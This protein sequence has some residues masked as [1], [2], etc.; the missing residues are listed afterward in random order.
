MNRKRRDF[1]KI[2]GVSAAYLA[3]TSPLFANS[4]IDVEVEISKK[5][6]T[7]DRYRNEF[8][9]TYSNSQEHGFSNGCIDCSSNCSWE[10][11]TNDNG[12]RRKNQSANYPLID[13]KIP[14][15]NPSGCAIGA[16]L[17]QAM[18]EGKIHYP[19]QRIGARGEGKW[20]SIS[21]D[22]AAK[23]VAENIFELL[24][25]K[26]GGP[27]KLMFHTADEYLGEVRSAAGERFCRQLGAVKVNLSSE[28]GAKFG[29]AT[30]AYGDNRVGCTYDFLFNTDTIVLWGE[31][32]AASHIPDAHYI[33]EAKYN[34]AKVVV[35]SSEFNAS[36]RTADLWVPLKHGSDS[37][38]AMSIMNVIV[39]EK[40]YKSEFMKLYTDL[41]LLVDMDTKKLLRRSDIEPIESCEQ[42]YCW[43]KQKKEI[44]LMPGTADDERRTLRLKEFGIDPELEGSYEITDKNGFPINV[45]TVFELFKQ[46]VSKYRP[47]ETQKFTNVHPD[48]VRVLAN[49]ITNTKVVEIIVGETL[50]RAFNSVNT[51][52][53]IASICGITG[54]MGP[55]GGLHTHNEFLIAGFEQLSDFQG[56]YNYREASSF[57]SDFILGDVK[58]SFYAHYK[59]EDIKRSQNGMSKF[60]HS[61]IL[62]AMLK[63]GKDAKKSG[64]KPW[65]ESQSAIIV[66]NSNIFKGNKHRNSFLDKIK[67]LTYIGPKACETAIYSDI[68][69]PSH[70]Y[71]FDIKSSQSRYVTLSKPAA[72]I[73]SLDGAKDEW[74]IFSLIAKKLEEIANKVDNLAKSRVKDEKSYAREG[75]HDLANFYKEYVDTKHNINSAE[76]ALHTSFNT[77]EQFRHWSVEK[78]ESVGG[79]LELDE[80]A[81][82]SS[83]LYT[84]RAYNS[85]ENNL[86]RFEPLKTLS[87]RQTFYVD[88]PLYIRLGANTNSAMHT[89]RSQDRRYPF[90][91]STID[92]RW[93]SSQ[94]SSKI[95]L[96]L[97]R[98]M[99][100]IQVNPT[101]AAK[102]N[103]HDADRVKIFN[104]VGEF[105]CMAK[106][107]T[108]VPPD[109]ILIENGWECY[110]YVEN[111]S[112][113]EV[114]VKALNLL[115]MAEGWG[116]LKFSKVW[117]GVTHMFD[118]SVDFE[119]VDGVKG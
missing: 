24:T 32:M 67:F 54:R 6:T 116:H 84:N 60:E 92:S 26:R 29:G 107:S 112:P 42:F 36:A 74:E 78:M 55:Y 19:M 77:V 99:P 1:L 72:K 81:A 34:G 87:G 47:E 115:E 45:T 63:D 118:S 76:D 51:L 103:I 18:Q 46:S 62:S 89:I 53:N 106:L 80:R 65:W 83:P 21:W 33:S 59:D 56:K 12:L 50:N 114:A 79:F 10:V 61:Q 35:I 94:R 101:T 48:T 109:T 119:K 57:I 91:L 64:I 117:D 27:Q 37:I 38:L 90:I 110:N 2:S 70:E 15:T 73:K 97:Q 85:F 75:Y 96:Q 5:L 4:E 41:P 82:K 31:N 17:S 95:L 14:D 9:A 105:E 49:D 44:A 113:L 22:D 108:T 43:D 100:Y 40:M 39:N 25:D 102:K 98:G 23:K 104:D 30:V 28:N 71:T 58:K 8:F 3:T 69:L 68:L 13:E 11:W 86:Y 93:S 52:W 66:G 88:H 20:E 16:Q 111:K 7:E